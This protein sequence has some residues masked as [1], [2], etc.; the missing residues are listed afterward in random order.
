MKSAILVLLASLSIAFAGV[1]A[2]EDPV[3]RVPPEKLKWVSKP[4][5]ASAA[6]RGPSGAAMSRAAPA[7]AARI[8]STG[9][10]AWAMFDAA[11]L[12]V[13]AATFWAISASPSFCPSAESVCP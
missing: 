4:S 7:A 11:D 3:V 10:P 9:P 6:M 8:A 2:G 12:G 1:P 5:Y 13:S